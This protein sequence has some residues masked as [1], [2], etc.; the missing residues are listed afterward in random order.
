MAQSTIFLTYISNKILQRYV[1]SATFIFKYKNT[2]R[3]EVI[4]TTNRTV[5]DKDLCKS[6][7]WIIKRAKM[8]WF[9]KMWHNHRQSSSANLVYETL[10]FF[11][12]FSPTYTDTFGISNTHTNSFYSALPPVFTTPRNTYHFSINNQESLEMF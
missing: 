4:N 6:A 5:F 8:G 11:R 1:L 12:S 2:N 3:E 7:V 10:Y 9:G